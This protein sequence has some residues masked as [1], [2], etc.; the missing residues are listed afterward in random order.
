LRS[1]IKHVEAE[2]QKLIPD[3]E[4]RARSVR[5]TDDKLKGLV[6]IVDKADDGV[7]H[8]FCRKIGV[9]NIREY[10][11]VQLRMAREEDEAMAEFSAQLAR[12]THM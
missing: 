8:A 12:F 3:Q 10:E 7:F 6:D 5:T 4:K 11:D 2:L 9:V 1:E